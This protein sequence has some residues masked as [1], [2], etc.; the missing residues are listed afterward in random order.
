MPS[1]T[2]NVARYFIPAPLP[3]LTLAACGAPAAPISP[4]YHTAPTSALT[5]SVDLIGSYVLAERVQHRQ[6]RQPRATATANEI[7]PT[8]P[9]T[10]REKE[11][12]TL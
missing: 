1:R 8:R 12:N 7:A 6:I 4:A 9:L 5:A 10:L 2:P 3:A 11:T